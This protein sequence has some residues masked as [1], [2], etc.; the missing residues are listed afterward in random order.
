[1]AYLGAGEGAATGAAVGSIV[2]GVGT[3]VGGIIGG[4][5]DFIGGIFG[6][7]NRK[8]GA[9]DAS[10]LAM[11]WYRYYLQREP[12]PQGRLWWQ[13]Q[14]EQD[15]PAKAWGNFSASPEF[16]SKGA[17]YR[18]GFMRDKYGI[19]P[20]DGVPVAYPQPE[21]GQGRANS[22]DYGVFPPVQ[23]T[24]PNYGPI[25]LPPSAIPPVLQLPASG[26]PNNVP[27]N[28][29]ISTQGGG[30]SVAGTQVNGILSKLGRPG[31]F[32]VTPS[33]PNGDGIDE[34][35]GKLT[36]DARASLARASMSMGGGSIS[37]MMLALGGAALVGIVALSMRR[38]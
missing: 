25:V 11:K 31:G 14:I 7:D 3:A 24:P 5:A 12:D 17:G 33:D 32:I 38:K 10:Q 28:M 1:M 29:P 16:A 36:D 9:H 19:E 27:Y 26:A 20:T 13:R 30:G 8:F 15:G 18:V 22:P 35:T 4:A 37:P 21:P 6:G 34:T 23:V 2:P